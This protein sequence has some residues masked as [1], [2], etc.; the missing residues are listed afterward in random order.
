ML[1]HFIYF[2]NFKDLNYC[3]AFKNI[4]MYINWL[5]NLDYD[6]FLNTAEELSIEK[7]TITVLK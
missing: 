1:S 2:P 6:I 4:K 5:H 3:K 7:R